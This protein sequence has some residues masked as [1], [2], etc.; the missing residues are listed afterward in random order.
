[1]VRNIIHRLKDPDSNVRDACVDTIR[2]GSALCLS[3]V[4]DNVVDPQ[5]M[6]RRSINATYLEC[7]GSVNT[8]TIAD[9]GGGEMVHALLISDQWEGCV[10]VK[11]LEIHPDCHT[12]IYALGTCLVLRHK[13]DERSQE[14]LQGHS[15]KVSCLAISKDGRYL[16]TGQV[17]FMGFAADIIIWDLDSRKL[18]HRMSLHKFQRNMYSLSMK[19]GNVEALRNSLPFIQVLSLL[20]IIKIN[21]PCK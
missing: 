14:F 19:H 16:A 13:N 6:G 4:I 5:P 20:W 17:I 1:M 2:V 12:L 7:S 9:Y 11:G 10:G 3:R 8:R 18:L 21:P 15:N